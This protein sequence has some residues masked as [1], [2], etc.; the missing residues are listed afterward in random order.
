VNKARV[1]MHA[2]WTVVSDEQQ[3]PMVAV[4]VPDA[5]RSETG[6]DRTPADGDVVRSGRLDMRH[7]PPRRSPAERVVLE[8]CD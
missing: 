4:L 1:S 3:E 5:S 6:P 7:P 2:D 8:R